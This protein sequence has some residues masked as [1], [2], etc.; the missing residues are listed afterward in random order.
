[1]LHTEDACASGNKNRTLT[2]VLAGYGRRFM[3]ATR[4]RTQLYACLLLALIGI[5]GA[6]A[7]Q[8]LAG[9]SNTG[10]QFLSSPSTKTSSAQAIAPLVATGRRQAEFFGEA[11]PTDA[12]Q[13]ADWVARSG[14]NH[15]LPFIIVDKVNAR[16]FVFEAAGRLKGASGVL[17]GLARG[18]DTVPGIG[19]RKV[20][21]VRPDE[22]I[23]PAGRFNASMGHDANKHDVLWVDYP[24]GIALHR[25]VTSNPAERRLQRLASASPGDKR[26]SY[27]CINVSVE[28][29]EKIIVPGF[30]KKNGVVYI[31]PEVKLIRAV[32]PDLTR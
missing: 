15:G 9:L 21:S 10:I 8:N 4:I 12:R 30:A 7:A 16:V 18:D 13:M 25:V 11:V 27:G 22:R 14:D 32:F 26:I 1:M 23:T 3:F 29:F 2:F 19:D 17:V 6:V 31:M 20:S 28:F 24:N 5:P